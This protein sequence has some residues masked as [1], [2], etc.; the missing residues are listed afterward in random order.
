LDSPEDISWV[1][2]GEQ[3]WIYG[4]W[5]V[6][7]RRTCV[8]FETVEHSLQHDL[9]S[10][11]AHPAISS[12]ADGIFKA[13]AEWGPRVM[14]PMARRRGQHEPRFHIST[15]TNA[16]RTRTIEGLGSDLQNHL[17]FADLIRRLVASTEHLVKPDARWRYTIQ[18]DEDRPPLDCDFGVQ[19][20]QGLAAGT[21]KREQQPA[22]GGVGATA[23]L[24]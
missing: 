22:D 1:E 21:L 10:V 9:V 11:A 6:R 24:R 17:G 18:A 5:R 8:L 4:D 20:K 19:F 14:Q 3:E 13:A 16:G 2:F 7:Q 23:D 15:Q 12:V